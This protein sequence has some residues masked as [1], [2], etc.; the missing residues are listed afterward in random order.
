MALELP[1]HLFPFQ[2]DLAD[3]LAH[4]G[5]HV[6]GTP[7]GSGKSVMSIAA[8]ELLGAMQVLIVCPSIM[9]AD[10]A[11]KVREFAQQNYA[12]DFTPQTGRKGR[13]VLAVSYEQVN[14][15]A[16]RHHVLSAMP[17]PDV[18]VLDEGQRLRNIGSAITTSIYGQQAS[19]KGL[20]VRAGAVWPTSGTI[21][22]NHIGDIFPHIHALAPHLLPKVRGTPMNHGQFMDHFALSQRTKYGIKVIGMQHKDELRALVNSFVF[23][24]DRRIIQAQFPPA[25]TSLRLLPTD[26]LDLAK[27]N[28]LVT[29]DGGKELERAVEMGDI[30]DYTPHLPEA[31][32]I[33]GELKAAAVARYVREILLTDPEASVLVF[34]HHR[35]VLKAIADDLIDIDRHRGLIHGETPEDT[36]Q[37]CITSLQN[38][39]SRVLVMGIGTAREGITL[40]RANR[41]ILAEASW[42]PAENEQAIARAARIGQ[43]RTVL[44]E[45][46]CIADT[47]DEALMRVCARK[48]HQLTE[49][50]HEP[51]DA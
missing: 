12:V 22:V 18:I 43:L 23:Q 51:S 3:R 7:P 8:W 49:V 19:G 36:R 1:A 21:A 6:L 13:A 2:A 39:T 5:H 16:R 31:R 41:V 40:T 33:L 11:A 14:S 32:R 26:E 17:H 20:C 27:Y 48:S 30:W 38:G 28:E 15:P 42:V 45:Y 34:G 50:F 24:C 47:L 4:A 46:V 10:W 29:S 37:A 35:S 25:L 44:A 9:R